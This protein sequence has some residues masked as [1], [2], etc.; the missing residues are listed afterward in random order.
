M[1]SRRTRATA[2]EGSFC[3]CGPPFFEV[4]PARQLF[5]IHLD[6]FLAGPASLRT[7]EELYGAVRACVPSFFLIHPFLGAEFTPGRNR[8]QHHFLSNR[9]RKVMNDLAGE[10]RALIT[11]LEPLFSRAI[12][13]GTDPAIE[14]NMIRLGQT[15]FTSDIFRVQAVNSSQFFLELLIAVTVG[16]IDPTC[17]T[18]KSAGCRKPVSVFHCASPLHWF[19]SLPT[20]HDR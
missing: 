8:P 5:S 7:P 2:A 11:P 10:L 15:S 16:C 1:V 13:Y 12:L 14:E 18:V 3:P 20:G 19:C 9:D 4:A 17:S 6:R